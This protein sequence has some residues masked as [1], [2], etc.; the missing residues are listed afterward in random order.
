[1][2]VSPFFCKTILLNIVQYVDYETLFAFMLVNKQWCFIAHL[3]IKNMDTRFIVEI[4]NN[5]FLY[6]NKYTK[7]S[8]VLLK[9]PMRCIKCIRENKFCL[10]NDYDELLEI[11]IHKYSDNVNMYRKIWNRS[12]ANDVYDRTSIYYLYYGLKPTNTRRMINFSKCYA[13]DIEH[14]RLCTDEIP[15][16]SCMLIETSVPYDNECTEG[17][18]KNNI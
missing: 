13:E 2:S 15:F 7:L 3:F 4:E 1:M 18:I 8:Y 5:N 14:L 9:T 16:V 11:S 10:C 12:M 17:I 6:T